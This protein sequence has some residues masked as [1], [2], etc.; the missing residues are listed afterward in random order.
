VKRAE[1]VRIGR[2]AM[3]P[4]NVVRRIKTAR[5]RGDSFRKIADRLNSA[6]VATGHGGAAWHPSTVRAVLKSR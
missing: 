4:A 1:G 3:V 6:E 2:P 5:T